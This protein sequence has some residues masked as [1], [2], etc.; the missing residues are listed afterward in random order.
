[1][2]AARFIREEMEVLLFREER[3][4]VSADGLRRLFV[5]VT[6]VDDN[7][8]INAVVVGVVGVVVVSVFVVFDVREDA[9]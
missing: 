7:V 3:G 6:F 4:R 5:D 1:M 8:G 2:P 9:R